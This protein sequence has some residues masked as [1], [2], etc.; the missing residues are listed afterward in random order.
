MNNKLQELLEEYS[1]YS[2]LYAKQIYNQDLWQEQTGCEVDEYFDYVSCC[3][4][5]LYPF[6]VWFEHSYS[7]EYPSD[8]DWAFYKDFKHSLISFHP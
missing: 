3:E 2:K 4:N 5:K 1:D 8:P 7:V 6:S